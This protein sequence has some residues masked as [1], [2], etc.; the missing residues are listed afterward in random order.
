MSGYLPQIC[1]RMLLH[2]SQQFFMIYSMRTPRNKLKYQP[3]S[4]FI[5]LF[6]DTN[7][8]HRNPKRLCCFLYRVPFFQILYNLNAQIFTVTC[9]LFS[10]FYLPHYTCYYSNVIRKLVYHQVM[11]QSGTFTAKFQ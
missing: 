3:F 2:I 6:P 5:H 4:L 7:R 8:L 11:L 10:L 1:V 9:H